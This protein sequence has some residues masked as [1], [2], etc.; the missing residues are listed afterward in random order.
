[1]LGLEFGLTPDKIDGP[2]NLHSSYPMVQAYYEWF[3]NEFGTT[4]CRELRGIFAE[5]IN[6]DHLDIEQRE[7]EIYDELHRQCDK[8]TGRAASKITELIYESRAATIKVGI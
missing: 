5:R 4:N 8:L 3:K 6:Y 7:K 1:M 2:D